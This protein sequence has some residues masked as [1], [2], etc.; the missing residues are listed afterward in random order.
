MK[1]FD[2]K[3][4]EEPKERMRSLSLFGDRSIEINYSTFLL[5]PAVHDDG[6]AI[7]ISHL[8]GILANGHCPIVHATDLHVSLEWRDDV[9]DEVPSADSGADGKE[10]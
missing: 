5:R 1:D 2:S 3:L 7:A 4:V 6:K 9:R 10:V 8:V